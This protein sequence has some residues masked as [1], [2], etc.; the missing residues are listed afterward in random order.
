MHLER[1]ELERE[2]LSLR[3]KYPATLKADSDGTEVAGEHMYSFASST[4]SGRL[5]RNVFQNSV[6]DISLFWWARVRYNWNWQL[7]FNL[8]C[9]FV[10]A[11]DVLLAAPSGR[12]LIFEDTDNPVEDKKL[13]ISDF[14]VVDVTGFVSSSVSTLSSGR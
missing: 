13:V 8:A 1:E 5:L 12:R 7:A 4:S 11:I 9:F 6:D 14:D 2:A 10:S 3:F